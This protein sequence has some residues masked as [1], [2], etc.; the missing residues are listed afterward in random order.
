MP[1]GSMNIKSPHY[2]YVPE[3]DLQ[4]RTDTEPTLRLSV[5]Y[6]AR[7]GLFC[8]YHIYLDNEWIS[9]DRREAV[10]NLA[11]AVGVKSDDLGQW[12]IEYFPTCQWT[13][14]VQGSIDLREVIPLTVWNFDEWLK[15]KLA[16]KGA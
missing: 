1:W 4:I 11:V 13:P 5:V 3:L 10:H 6:I 14:L 2:F 12:L 9:R 8:G 7:F 15:A 16:E